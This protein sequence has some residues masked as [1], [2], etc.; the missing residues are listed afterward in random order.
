[1]AWHGRFLHAGCCETSAA[2]K[3]NGRVRHTPTS[4]RAAAIGHWV[5]A[6]RRRRGRRMPRRSPD[7]VARFLALREFRARLYAC[8]TARPDALFE[9]CDAIL[10][11]DHA[12]TSLVQLSLEA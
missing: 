2:R 1:M 11:A 6:R 3:G 12:V 10:C 9:L 4:R 7:A 5:P 8:L